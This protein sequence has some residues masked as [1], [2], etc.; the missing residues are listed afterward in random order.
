MLD[1]ETIYAYFK[2][3]NSVVLIRLA[4][5]ECD[6]LDLFVGKQICFCFPGQEVASALLNSVVPVPLFVWIEMK[7]SRRRQ[8][9]RSGNTITG[10]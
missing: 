4:S 3:A 7:L 10:S 6:R 1:H 5:E 8:T 9:S 2:L